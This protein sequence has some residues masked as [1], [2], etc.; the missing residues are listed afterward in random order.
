MTVMKNSI[1]ALLAVASLASCKKN[2]TSTVDSS[3][4]STMMM[5]ADSATMPMDS[6]TV[7]GASATVSD[8]DKTFADAAAKGGMMEVMLGELAEKNGA[9]AQVKALGKMIKDDHTK[10]NAELKNWAANTSYMLPTQLDADQQ[11]MVDDL[12]SKKGADF[13]KA[14][15]DM[16]V[17]DHNKD[18]A[19]FKK[20][21]S[22]G[23]GDLK[24]FAAKTVPTLE[25]HLKA[26]QDAMKGL[27]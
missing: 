17:M 12:K 7:S 21:A 10:A 15:T 26:S 8:Q 9:S 19:A 3:T 22:E 27:K 18:I 20:E 6:A 14:Y 1:L 2:E 11:K 24:A 16:M 4:D 23:T 25:A 5:P 13:D